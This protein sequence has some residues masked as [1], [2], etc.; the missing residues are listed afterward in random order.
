MQSWQSGGPA[1]PPEWFLKVAPISCRWQPPSG[2]NVKCQHCGDA[3]QRAWHANMPASS[4][5]DWPAMFRGQYLASFFQHCGMAVLDVTVS[6]VVI[7]VDVALSGSCMK[8]K[9][10][11]MVV[12]LTALSGHANPRCWPYW[13]HQCFWLSLMD[14]GL[15]QLYVVVVVAVVVHPRPPFL[16][17]HCFLASDQNLGCT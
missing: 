8:R 13:Q 4:V 15:S 1:V 16:Q 2:Q 10:V 3:L 9:V 14:A 12:P 6:V 5:R 11:V 7:E 17:H